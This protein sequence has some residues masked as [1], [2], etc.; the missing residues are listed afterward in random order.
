MSDSSSR[1]RRFAEAARSVA[2]LLSR[3]RGTPLS[4]SGVGQASSEP[5]LIIPRL[6]LGDYLDAND[7]VRLKSLG[8]THVLSV[9]E[10]PPTFFDF[11]ED[12]R[13]SLKT[14][15]IPLQ[16]SFRANILQHL[17]RTTEFIREALENP[18]S[19]VL[20]RMPVYILSCMPMLICV[21]PRQQ[22]HCFQG[23]S[24]SATVVA[25]YL[26]A[27]S[28]DFDSATSVLRFLKSRRSIA[29]PN[30]GFARQLDE[31][32]AICCERR[33]VRLGTKTL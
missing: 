1:K 6:Y 15:H 25:A 28:S 13:A 2:I 31:Y 19:I 22:V 9:L 10:D 26:L 33:R 12:Y 18:S 20:V 4:F 14:L 3:Q 16:D 7:G 5:S 30:I 24:R 11:A 23:I 8:V 17:D 27:A 29:A 21:P 32:A